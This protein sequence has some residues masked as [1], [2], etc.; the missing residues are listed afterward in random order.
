[1][2]SL[3]PRA[4]IEEAARKVQA[5]LTERQRT[6]APDAVR[7]ADRRLATESLALSRLLL[8]GVADRLRGEW[9]DKRLLV[10]ASGALAYLP[11]GAL[12]SPFE[13]PARPLLADHEIVS[14]PSASVVA[15]IRRERPAGTAIGA[16]PRVAVLADPVFDARDPRVHPAG[17]AKG[18]VPP[19]ATGLR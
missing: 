8:E 17:A 13:G 6:Q 19:P 15:A 11:F 18:A 10:V 2:R 4:R 5:L 16:R 3:P 1:M 7:E 9:K 12:P 14:A